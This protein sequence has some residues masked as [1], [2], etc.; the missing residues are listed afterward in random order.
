MPVPAPDRSAAEAPSAAILPGGL[1]VVQKHAASRLHYDL[2]L[3]IDGVLRSWA[4]P[5]GP[6][7]DP[8]EK[9]LA[10][11]V[12]EHPLDYADFEG[13]IAAGNYGAGE[14][15]VWDRGRW[16]P[17]FEPDYPAGLAEGK[18]L[19]ELD[20]FKLRGRWALIK[21]KG[22]GRAANEWL[23][24]KKADAYAG[25]DVLS[26]TSIL[27][28]RTVEDIAAGRT[29]GDA[30]RAELERLGVPRRAV[31]PTAVELMLAET[32]DAPPRD[33]GWI[34]E[35]KYDG[36]RLLA[37]R[38][39]G[40]AS[41][42]YRG[43]SEVAARYPDVAT[44]IATLPY[45]GLVLDGELVV[46]NPEGRASFGLLQQR[47]MLSRTL[48]IRL[49]ALRLPAQLMC[50]D[51]LAFEGFDLRDLPLLLRKSLLERLLPAA[52]PLRYCAHIVE[53]GAE[54]FEHAVRMGLEGVIGKRADSSYRPGRSAKWVK[55]K[56]ARTGDFAVVGWTKPEG[57]RQGLGALHLAYAS[58]EAPSGYVYAGGVGTGFDDATLN[59]TRRRL[60]TLRRAKP[61][62]E[63]APRL[64]GSTWVDP[65]IVAEVRFHEWT[66]DDTLRQAVFLRFRDDKQPAECTEGPPT[67]TR[68]LAPA[69]STTPV[70]VPA[71]A[72]APPA[73]ASPAAAPP[74]PVSRRPPVPDPAS[75]SLTNL[76]KPFWPEDGYAKGDLIGFYRE[77]APA[78]LPYLRDRPLV[79][80]RFPDGIH[81]KS[82]FQQDAPT[83]IPPWIRTES[84][85]SSETRKETRFIIANDAS[86]LLYVANLGSIPLHVW[87]SRVHALQ[88]PDWTI[89]D[90]DPKGAPFSDVVLV[91]RQLHALCE[92]LELPSFVKTSGKSGLHVLVPLGAQVT[93]DQGRELALLLAQ[94]VVSELP[95]QATLQ[96]VIGARGGRVYID[97][98]QNGHGK[99]LVAPLCV[100]P[101]PGAPV[102]TPLAWSEVNGK[103]DPRAF[104]IR[105]VPARLAKQKRDPFLDVIDARPDLLGALTRLQERLARGATK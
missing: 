88:A 93:F 15:I 67:V 104:T 5:R 1:F 9:R 60:E 59:A 11:A 68:L 6:S 44:A 53:R 33:T 24:V 83:H 48:E 50:F 71:A 86:T 73:A 75:L 22:K 77:I 43:G 21:T 25:K 39:H 98:Y 16:T 79:L 62:C 74:A 64:R 46:C 85:W 61:P 29:P 30:V 78:I 7:P 66:H 87:S 37:A 56:G 23:L 55:L 45:E 80:T 20:G 34:W 54:T 82:F 51:L 12:E 101:E 49:A 38:K 92:D 3:E 58:P 94:V 41:L 96:R 91:A 18:L 72:P 32:R 27:T 17:I 52:G 47:A 28:G 13:V 8:A 65:V 69:A 102:S 19:F 81:G 2:R 84:M 70:P 100:R 4:V 14:V 99:L 90:L 26:E 42:F 35:I 63:H 95:G 97:C 10:M 76:K 57:A 89:L 105:T 31:D 103:L 36:F 40:Q